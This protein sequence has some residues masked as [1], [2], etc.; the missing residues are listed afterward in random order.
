MLTVFLCAHSLGKMYVVGQQSN[1][2]WVRRHAMATVQQ[3]FSTEMV[4]SLAAD[5][6]TEST[7]AAERDTVF[8]SRLGPVEEAMNLF[9][10]EPNEA[11]RSRLNTAVADFREA[12]RTTALARWRGL[13][14][15]PILHRRASGF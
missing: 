15:R 8:A 10:R 6:L 2:S 13:V 14:T 9:C 4:Y 3:R 7:P 11:T 12:R 1:G 5:A